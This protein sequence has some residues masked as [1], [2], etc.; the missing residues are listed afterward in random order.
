M[1]LMAKWMYWSTN[2]LKQGQATEF[3]FAKLQNSFNPLSQL[4]S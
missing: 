2:K 1:L 3:S 4:A